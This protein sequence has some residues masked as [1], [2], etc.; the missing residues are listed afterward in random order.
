MNGISR[1]YLDSLAAVCMRVVLQLDGVGGISG[2]AEE[3]LRVSKNWGLVDAQS[4]LSGLSLSSVG[5]YREVFH[6]GK[7][8]L[9]MPEDRDELQ[10]VQSSVVGVDE[11]LFLGQEHGEKAIDGDGIFFPAIQS[12]CDFERALFEELLLELEAGH[13]VNGTKDLSSGVSG[14]ERPQGFFGES[15]SGGGISVVIEFELLLKLAQLT[16]VFSCLE[17][18]FFS[19]RC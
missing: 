15:V 4:R 11:L 13:F 16:C 5:S 6:A 8:A 10:V 3:Q 12:S 2:A 18:C 19:S 1:E 17:I 14:V 9:S 7:V